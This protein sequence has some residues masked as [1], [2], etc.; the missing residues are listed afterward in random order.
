[1]KIPKF[2]RSVGQI[3]DELIANAADF[4]EKRILKSKPLVASVCAL[5][6]VG[7]IAAALFIN[8]L[9]TSSIDK[10]YKNL[11]FY[12]LHSARVWEWEDLAESERNYEV[13]I[14][15]IKYEKS[16]RR[17]IRQEF[18]GEKIGRFD[19]F[20][21]DTIMILNGER[22]KVTCDIYKLKGISQTEFIAIKIGGDYYCFEN[23]LYN[24]PK[25]LGELFD[26]VDISRFFELSRFSENGSD[27]NAKHF[28][29][30]DDEYV[31][32]IL[33]ECRSAEFVDWDP[34]NLYQR[35]Y[36]SFS[37]SSDALGIY[38]MD[39]S[40]TKDGYL[41]T[42]IFGG[43]YLFNIG[44]KAA[45][46]IIGYSAENSTKTQF[47]P[48]D[49]SKKVYGQVKEIADGYVLIDDAVLCKNKGKGIT[50]KIPTDDIRI[51]RHFKT[52]S[53]KVG[54]LIAVSYDG[55]IDEQNG[56]TVKGA[57]DISEFQIVSKKK[58]PNKNSTV[59]SV[60]HTLDTVSANS[61]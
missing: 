14:D 29:L 10:R 57:F 6:T 31:W 21:F 39:F 32:N 48:Y 12:S 55:E 59:S 42:N 9:N 47:L 38:R 1:M 33:S 23:A 61:D 35:E 46:E 8:N 17:T 4:K 24:P 30:K 22:V 45:N 43:A 2:A 13:E 11:D 26:R 5:L 19:V 44:K 50:Y 15:G 54:E 36:I 56:H 49:E 3:D 40:I 58:K 37:A 27:A 25:T 53:T 34:F 18:I 51:S 20:G 16:S 60:S 7:I 28:I 41:Y 52:G